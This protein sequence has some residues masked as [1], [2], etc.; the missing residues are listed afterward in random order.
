MREI[1]SFIELEFPKGNEYYTGDI[2][3]ARLNTGRAAIWHAFRLTGAK[4]IWIPYYQCK[5]VREFLTKKGV[6]IKYYHQD[7]IFNPMDLN[8]KPDE[9]VLLVN[10]FGLRWLGPVI[11]IRV[12]FQLATRQSRFQSLSLIVIPLERLSLM[13]VHSMSNSY[14]QVTLQLP[15]QWL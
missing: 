11:Y 1:G 6:E 9:A 15:Q 10:Y 4:A 12:I 13:E 2:N 3:V 7:K 5:T 8:A 14:H